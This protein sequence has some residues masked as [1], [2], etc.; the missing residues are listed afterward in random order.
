MITSTLKA[1]DADLY[2]CDS[3][4]F[5]SQS[6]DAPVQKSTSGIRLLLAPEAR[7]QNG[8]TYPD[9]ELDTALF[10]LILAAIT[11]ACH[12]RTNQMQE[13]YIDHT[14]FHLLT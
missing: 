11:N 9:Q 8:D 14:A 6:F 3:Y 10:S 1:E 13:L 12:R 4:C 7:G 2:Y 5:F